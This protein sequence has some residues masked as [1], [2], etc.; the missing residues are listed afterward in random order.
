MQM[1]SADPR[2]SEQ[3]PENFG[4]RGNLLQNSALDK[5]AQN[6][7]ENI[8]QSISSQMEMKEPEKDFRV[9]GFNQTQ[10]VFAEGLA[11]AVIEEALSEAYEGLNIEDHLEE[12]H[13][14]LSQSGLPLLGSLDYPDPPPSTPLLP[15]L[16]RSKCSF[17]RKLKGG[18]AKVFL[19]SPPPP[20][21][22][23]KEDCPESTT[24]DSRMEFMEHLMHS[25]PMDDLVKD[26]NFEV[27]HHGAQVEAFAQAL[28][29]DLINWV[30]NIKEPVADNSELHLLAQQMVEAIITSSL[31][32]ARMLI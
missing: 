27:T 12:T 1:M 30:L 10:E 6:M 8:I 22:K 28:S 23:D 25:L 13:P 17:A 11:S 29:C 18:L 4:I 24:I 9:P 26:Y 16:E 32:E 3:V 15:E 21:P 20:T 14:P 7:T 31:D 2:V 19:P 5:F